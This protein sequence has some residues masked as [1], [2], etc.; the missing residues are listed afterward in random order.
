MTADDIRAIRATTGMTQQAFAD[1]YR[2]KVATLRDWERGRYVTETG[3]L[4]L[5]RSTE[6][7]LAMI[8]ADHDLAALLIRKAF[9]H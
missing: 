4:V 2:L 9:A 1:A 8:R 5:D 7:L 3:E 6:T